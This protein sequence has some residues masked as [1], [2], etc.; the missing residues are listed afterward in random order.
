MWRPG[1][2]ETRKG[3]PTPEAS[4]REWEEE[5]RKGLVSQGSGNR[6]WLGVGGW[7]GVLGERERSA[8]HPPLQC[9]KMHR[10]QR[11]LCK[12]TPV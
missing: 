3:L 1:A 12:R 10:G 11:A 7:R 5:G 9:R 6:A 8:S 2:T 4:Q